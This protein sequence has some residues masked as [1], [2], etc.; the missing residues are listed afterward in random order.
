MLATGASQ[1]ATRGIAQERNAP[2]DYRVMEDMKLQR[3]TGSNR[4]IL[5]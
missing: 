3:F 1:L 2:V 5:D 4:D